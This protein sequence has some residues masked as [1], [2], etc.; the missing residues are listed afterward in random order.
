MRKVGLGAI[1][2]ASFGGQP[3]L[4]SQTGYMALLGSTEF[5]DSKQTVHL[6]EWKSAK[7]GCKVASTPATGRSHRR[8]HRVQ[9]QYVC[10]RALCR[11]RTACVLVSYF[12]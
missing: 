5:W 6:I 3:N 10:T 7:I 4:K 2:D 9:S 11:D 1:R 8:I 12:E